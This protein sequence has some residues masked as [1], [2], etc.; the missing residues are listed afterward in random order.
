MSDTIIQLI[1][2]EKSQRLDKF[3]AVSLPDYSRARLQGLMKDGFVCV[4][5]KVVTKTGTE[6]LPGQHVEVRIPPA[7]PSGL[8]AEEIPLEIIFED[9][10]LMVVNKPA[11]M[12]V[13]PAAGHFTGTLVHAALAHSPEME[14]IGGEIR[15]GVVHRLDKD[16]SGL[17]LMA[18]DERTHRWLQ[19]QFR[20]R[21][22]NKIY[23]ALVDGAPPTPKGRVEAPIGR[24]PSHRKQ[25]AITTL[26]KG[27]MAVSE[28]FTRESFP[29]HTLL[30]VHPLTGR[31]HQIRLHMAFLGCPIVGDRLYG[32]RRLSLPVERQCLHAWRITI[33]LPGEKTART[34]EA[35]IPTDLQTV[36]DDLRK[37]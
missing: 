36:L 35:G 5:G 34:F 4:D 20:L 27:R 14:G 2:Q 16:T 22:V 21:Q 15:P 37:S 9:D 23:L 33:I 30:D 31:T 11:G 19:D 25:M 12:V 29:H 28:Y 8:V 7:M 24:D 6:A 26:E 10:R 3:L 18:K 13:H 17:I 1:V 32:H